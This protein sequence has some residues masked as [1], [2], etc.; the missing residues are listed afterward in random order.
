M[1]GILR[2]GQ[3][4]PLLHGAVVALFVFADGLLDLFPVGCDVIP[5][6]FQVGGRQRRVGRQD[7]GIGHTQAATVVQSFPASPEPSVILDKIAFFPK[8]KL[9]N[10]VCLWNNVERLTCSLFQDKE[11]FE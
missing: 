10:L 9:E 1:I 5:C 8:K 6:G 2:C 11:A 4:P 7:F 3:N